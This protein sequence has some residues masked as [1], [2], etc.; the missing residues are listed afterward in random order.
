MATSKNDSLLYRRTL[1]Q[2]LSELLAD[3]L[4][5]LTRTRQTALLIASSV[6]LLVSTRLAT[7]GEIG[8][9]GVKL[10][11]NA[12]QLAKWLAF[13]VTCY[14]FIAYLLGAWADWLIAETKGWSPLASIADVK[15]AMQAD[16]DSLTEANKFWAEK[17]KVVAPQVDQ[18]T[19]EMQAKLHH[20]YAQADQVEAAL[21]SL[22][23]IGS[24]SSEERERRRSLERE[25][26]E[27]NTA[28]TTASN[29]LD[30]RLAPLMAVVDEVNKR[31]SWSVRLAMSEEKEDLTNKLSTYSILTRL[32]L[33]LEIIFP[34]IY[35]LFALIWTLRR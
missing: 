24:A 7:I 23:Q 21:S 32:R 25:Q 14:L 22:P 8:A 19:K 9:G 18:T 27:L 28:M 17:L 11:L 26:R 6:A 29:E 2:P 34:I 5:E 31:N 12:P 35:A 30:N 20:L 4:S 3:P 16:E 13:A 15:A 1:S 33:L 10:T